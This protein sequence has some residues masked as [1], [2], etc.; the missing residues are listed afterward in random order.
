MQ[1]IALPL[2]RNNGDGPER[3]VIGDANASTAEALCEPKGWPYGTAILKG[4]PRSGKSLFLRWF[5]ESG[6]GEVIDN[7]PLMDEDALFHR[8]NRA[9][10]SGTLL[11][12]AAWDGDWKIHLPDLRSRLSAAMQ[13]HIGPPDD[14]MAGELILSLAQ[15]RGLPLHPEAAAYLVPRVERSY[16]ALERLVA[17][18]DRISMERKAPPTLAIWRAALDWMA[19]RQ[20]SRLP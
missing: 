1:Q 20:P 9:Q 13:L 6:L 3:I 7:A 17:A 15:Q 10:E 5:S 12:L 4:P 2:R 18:I 16:I 11:L 14:R 19:D 8:W